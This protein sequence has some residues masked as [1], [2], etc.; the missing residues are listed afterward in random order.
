ME[1]TTQTPPQTP[2]NHIVTPMYDTLKTKDRNT[3]FETYFH[4]DN[5]EYCNV[6]F[7]MKKILD[8]TW[9]KI[10]NDFK[11]LEIQEDHDPLT[12]QQAFYC[13]C[14]TCSIPL[15][16]HTRLLC[17]GDLCI[18]QTYKG[19]SRD[20]KEQMYHYH[21]EQYRTKKSVEDLKDELTT[22]NDDSDEEDDEVA[23]WFNDT[24]TR[25][26]SA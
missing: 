16:S 14:V 19:F 10:S 25:C 20:I 22:I 24:T 21:M 26:S 1:N 6:D 23:R 17:G 2:R 3:A 13:C 18:N 11:T 5:P 7:Q 8:E 12:V 9:D 15:R 4:R